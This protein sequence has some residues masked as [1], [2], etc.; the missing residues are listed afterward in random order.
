M[1]YLEGNV[2]TVISGRCI[3]SYEKIDPNTRSNL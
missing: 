3:T 1:L 2:S